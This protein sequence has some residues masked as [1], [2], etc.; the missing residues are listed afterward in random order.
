MPNPQQITRQEKV[1][2]YR[3]PGCGANVLFEEQEGSLRCPACGR[4]EE[5]E[6]EG[7]TEERSYE[8]YLHPSNDQLG[9]LATNALEVRCQ[10]CSATVT[11]TPPEV[12]DECAFCGSK[13][14]AQPKPADP[15]VAPE[16]VLPFRLTQAESAE[17]VRSWFKSR[18]FAPT[19]LKNLAAHK[20]VGGV[21]IPFWG[22]DMRAVTRYRGQRGDRYSETETYT[23]TDEKGNQVTKTRE[24]ERTSWHDVLGSVSRWFDDTLVPATKSLP[25]SRL[26]ALEP[27]DLADLEPYD[28]ARLSGYKAQ[29][30]QVDLAEGFDQAKAMVAAAIEEEVRYDIG[31]SEQKI[32]HVSTRYSAIRFKHMLLPI[33]IGAYRFKEK[34]YQVVVNARTGEVQGER[35]YSIG[36]IL[37]F[38]LCLAVAIGLVVL[39]LKTGSIRLPGSSPTSVAPL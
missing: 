2:R 8:E 20:P 32:D 33:Y 36:K 39:L 24:I 25:Q 27:W 35:P 19:A 23:E 29:R 21:Y 16:H 22:Y 11:F 1:H 7:G 13:I 5:G 37:L 4:R 15:L 3:C 26:D 28:P 34:V 12:V 6:G 17:R 14:V 31:G 18:W 10:G 9:T 38:V 30:Y